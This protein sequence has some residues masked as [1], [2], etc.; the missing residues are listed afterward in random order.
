MQFMLMLK[1][2]PARN[3]PPTPELY[4]AIGKLTE[5]MIKSGI[6]VQTGGMQ[7][8]S[9][10]TSVKLAGGKVSVTDGPFAESKEV[11]GGFAIIDVESREKAIELAREF[12]EIH[13]KIMGRSYE[14]ESEVRQMFPATEFTQKAAEAR[15]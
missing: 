10:I 3:P 7:G 4:A 14:M 1:G 5:E 9:G 11:T 2:D 6:L 13:G 12:L 15:A 8:S